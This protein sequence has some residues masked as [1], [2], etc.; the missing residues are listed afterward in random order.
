[1][2]IDACKITNNSSIFLKKIRPSTNSNSNNVVLLKDIDNNIQVKKSRSTS[3][4][5]LQSVGLSLVASVTK[6]RSSNN[7]NT[8]TT[9]TNRKSTQQVINKKHVSTNS[10]PTVNVAPVTST[11]PPPQMRLRPSISARPFSQFFFP[12]KEE[13]E[14]DTTFEQPSIMYNKNRMGHL[15]NERGQL[16][17]QQTQRNK[18]QQQQKHQKLRACKKLNTSK[19]HSIA[20]DFNSSHEDTNNIISSSNTSSRSSSLKT[21]K[22]HSIIDNVVIAT[23]DT[24][25][26]QSEITFAAA[27]TNTTAKKRN[28][29][30]SVSQLQQ[31]QQQNSNSNNNRLSSVA[32]ARTVLRLD[33]VKSRE[34]RA[35]SVWKDTVSQLSLDGLHYDDSNN[36]SI[37]EEELQEDNE[38]YEILTH[39]A[40]I[41]KYTKRKNIYGQLLFVCFYF[42]PSNMYIFGVAGTN[43]GTT[44]VCTT[45]FPKRYGNDEIYIK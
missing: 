17:P 34:M 21:V 24:V 44:T 7:N 45:I 31:V 29:S 5:K 30:R 36:S 28:L 14:E 40:L 35:I 16:P 41:V 37:E 38:L 39:P 15:K 33:S 25:E 9:T 8:A 32:R 26:I 18:Q 27:T 23:N 10:L 43:S 42:S 19:R 12:I 4:N 6:K 22:S 1:M 2:S 11:L 3:L 13:K 20:V